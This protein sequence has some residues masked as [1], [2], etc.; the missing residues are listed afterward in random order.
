M[1][2]SAWTGYNTYL[3]IL[4]LLHL[5]QLTRVIISQVQPWGISKPRGELGFSAYL[6]KRKVKKERHKILKKRSYHW[7]RK[8]IQPKSHTATKSFLKALPDDSNLKNSK[9]VFPT[10]AQESAWW[11]STNREANGNLEEKLLF[12]PPILTIRM[13]KQRVTCSRTAGGFVKG[14]FM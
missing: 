10:S 8:I 11:K 1:L 12:F 14:S 4:L 2:A 6:Q 5:P 9:L 13:P 7:G 3:L